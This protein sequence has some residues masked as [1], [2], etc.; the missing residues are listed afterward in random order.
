MVQD[1]DLIA[2]FA[3]FDKKKEIEAGKFQYSAKFKKYKG[4]HPIT[5]EVTYPS[6]LVSP[7]NVMS[8]TSDS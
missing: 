5:K 7:T 8:V 1:G 2:E 3:K 4:E 6:P